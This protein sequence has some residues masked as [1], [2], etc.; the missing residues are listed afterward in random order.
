M[1]LSLT[2]KFFLNLLIAIG[3]VVI[4]MVFL[5]QYSFDRGFLNYVNTIEAKRLETLAESLENAYGKNGCWGF[6]R[7]NP[8]LLNGFLRD[9]MPEDSRPRRG[10]GFPETGRPDGPPGPAASFKPGMANRP[11]PHN[12]P[13]ATQLFEHR[14]VLVDGDGNTLFGPPDH[15]PHMK[16]LDLQYNHKPVGYLGLIPQQH[17][18]ENLQL[19]FV[20]E[21]KKA[22]V[23]I[24]LLTACIAVLLSLP[25]ARQMVKRIKALAAA[26]HRLTAGHYDTRLPAGAR[27]ELGWLIRDFNTLANTLAQNEQ[28]RRRFV[29]DISHELRTPL[30]V[31]RGE[32][33]ALQDN[34]RTAT[35]E[36][37]SSLHAEVMQL[38]RLVGDLFQLS[39]SDM[40][41]LTYRKENL[42]LASL[43]GE[44]VESF[45]T[46]FSEKAIS[47]TLSLPPE[48]QTELFGDPGRLQQLFEN[49]LSNSLKYTDPGG[50]F[51]MGLERSDNMLTIICQD[52]APGVGLAEMKKLFDR[53][54][55]VESSRSRAS[56]G[57]GLGLAICKKIFEA[58]EGTIIVE[59]SDL[60]GVSI[61]IELPPA[62]E[63]HESEDFSG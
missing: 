49:L 14:I 62:G 57:A 43:L 37:L 29:G 52:S 1:K 15:P 24:A 13:E 56:G 41:A 46:G 20:K 23:I 42:D 33:E 55:R 36:T 35:P 60:G 54:Y 48:G 17:L 34:V 19:R 4:S 61:K 27:D 11:P 21:Q 50:R 59:P 26:T 9:S 58:H 38:D 53:L 5:I 16:T 2:T 47:V 7:D 22:F 31:L 30:A 12:A 18:T 25:L 63:E 8:R 45:K 44:T 51:H 6:L 28:M 3:I 39:L 10:P 40:G 32:I